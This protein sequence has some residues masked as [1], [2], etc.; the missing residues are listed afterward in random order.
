MEGQELTWGELQKI[1]ARLRAAAVSLKRRDIVGITMIEVVDEAGIW[2]QSLD[3]FNLK[4]AGIDLEHLI[5]RVP[6]LIC[7]IAS[8]I[9]FAFEGV[10]T[11]FWAHFDEVIGH[12]ASISQRQRIAEA[13]HAE[14]SRYGLSRPSQ[15]AFSEHFS[16]IAWPIANALLPLDLVGPVMRL[17]SRAP[18]GALPGSGRIANFASL[19]AWASA[20]EGARLVD[21]LRLEAATARVLTAVLTE[22]RGKIL[23]PASY[24]RLRDQIAKQ[25]EA[26]FAARAAR[27]RA[28]TSKAPV[29]GQLTS[30]QLA[31]TLD[32]FGLR[33]FAT[34]PALPVPLFEEAR[35]I[36]RSAAWRPRLWNG[37]GFLHPDMALSPGPFALSF[38]SV[39]GDD[40]PAYPDAAATFGEGSEAAVALAARIIEWKTTLLFDPNEDRTRA[41]QRFDALTETSGYVWIAIRPGGASLEGLRRVGNACGYSV[42]EADLAAASDRSILTRAGLTSGERRC[43]IARHP[44]DAIGAPHGV[45]RPDRP[46]LIYTE[47]VTA[48]EE[49]LPQQLPA[50]G[51]LVPIPGSSGRPGLRVEPVAASVA[52]VVDLVLFERDNLFEALVE[53]RLQLRL[54]SPLPLIDVPVV[55][56]LEVGGRL[57]ARG[58]ASFA[59]VPVTVPRDSPLLA[60]LYHDY[61]RG[62]LLEIG[63]AS[64]RIAVHQ[65]ADLQ[66]ELERPATSVEWTDGAPRSVGTSFD[67]KLVA[68]QGSRPHRFASAA[69]VEKPDRGAIAYGLQ[70]SD[71]RIAD[72]VQIFTSDKFDLGDLTAQFR[73]DLGSRRMFDHGGGVGDIA[74]ALVAWSRGLCASLPAVAAKARIVRQFEEPLLISLCGRAWLRA[75]EASRSEPTDAHLA[76]WQFAL[77]RG[78]AHV[79][80]GF[81][82]G[83]VQAFTHAFQHHARMLDPDWPAGNELPADGA[84]DDALN[85]AYGD[86]VRERHA[87]GAL[88]DIDPDDVDFGS[89]AEDWERAAADALRIVRRPRLYELMA[90]SGGAGELSQRSYANLSVPELAEDLSAWT[91]RWALARGR[92]NPD[93]AAN[94]L[95]LWVSPAA[96]DDVDSVTHTLAVDPFVA[97]VVRYT[98][99][100]FSNEIAGNA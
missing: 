30:G 52:S 35:A 61:A 18:V 37:G 14:A 31:L 25:P 13:F 51:R 59:S 22:N 17:V 60:P 53:R 65:S 44:M 16:N 73:D 57:I 82:S 76:L 19:R 91:R 5:N 71:G 29:S 98:A 48:Q 97:R 42:F 15:S 39:P 84:M 79:P 93:V 80:A 81:A 67:A 32:A 46:F 55:A 58:R 26:F 8:E 40:E 88:L 28:R 47:D 21:W 24:Q 87:Q 75:E 54:E 10:G 33:M 4:D 49:H 99:L 92:M 9:G 90:P 77:E 27:L 95:Q 72:P 2:P 62:K 74:R 43:V 68:A 96:C 7:A 23:S 86:V 56:D 45:V 6:L 69:A 64:L 70:L 100:R 3:D 89:P 50:G 11:I 41:E 12:T 38:K 1:E 20:A 94:A 63:K 78:L 34:W 66:V 83:D 36:A 85:Q